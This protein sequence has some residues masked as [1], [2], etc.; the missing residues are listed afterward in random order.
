MSDAAAKIAARLEELWR[1]SRPLILERVAAVR[2][3][4]ETLNCDPEDVQARNRG[5]EAAHKLSGILGVFGLPRGSELAAELEHI[6]K[7]EHPLSPADLT[8]L[9]SRMADLDAIIAS[10]E[11]S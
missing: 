8:A 3:A 7:P 6:L 10:K 2:S 5:R 4:G 9:Q 1:S 11:S